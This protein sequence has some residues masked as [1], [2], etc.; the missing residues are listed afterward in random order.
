MSIVNPLGECHVIVVDDDE[1]C[2][3]EVVEIIQ[4]FGYTVDCATWV[5]SALQKIVSNDKIG[6]IVTDLI[7]PGMDGMTLL[8]ELSVRLYT[9]RP[10]VSIVITG[11]SSL[12][13]AVRAMNFN[14]SDFLVKPVTKS[15]LAASLRRATSHWAARAG[16]FLLAKLDAN[17]LITN[18]LRRDNICKTAGN[19]VANTGDLRKLVR[20][21]IIRQSSRVDFVDIGLIGDAGWDILLDILSAELENKAVPASSACVASRM[22]FSTG[23]R[24]INQLVSLGLVR[25][26]HDPDDKRRTLLALMPATK[27]S[28]INYFT[29]I[30]GTTFEERSLE[31]PGVK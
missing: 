20:S 9:V 25:R 12:D 29:A 8:E 24:Y 10:L 6:I 23:M 18:Q 31:P 17:S 26:W 15:D 28:L 11:Q 14:A 27:K 7:M 22:P 1:A 4:S 13:Q 21:T 30:S 3:E 19:L 16:Q 5:S 2:L